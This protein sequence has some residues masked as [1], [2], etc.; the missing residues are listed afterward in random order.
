MVTSRARS[1]YMNHMRMKKR[2]LDV[3]SDVLSSHGLHRSTFGDEG[4]N[5]RVRNGIGWVPFSMVAE[6]IK[7]SP[8]QLVCS[9]QFPSRT[10][11]ATQ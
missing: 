11:K 7:D 5:Y 3:S 2:I 4:L 9:C 6:H 8:R 10:L 1:F